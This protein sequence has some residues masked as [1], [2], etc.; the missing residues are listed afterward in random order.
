MKRFGQAAVAA[1]ALMATARVASAQLS[2]IPYAPVEVGTGISVAVDYA[3]PSSDLGGGTAYGLTGGVGFGRF[4]LSASFGAQDPSAFSKS[5]S[6][7]GRIGMR[8]FGGG[9]NPLSV[10]LQVGGSSTQNIGVNSTGGATTA[11]YVAPGAWAKVNLP[12]IKPWGQVYYTTGNNRP[13]WSKDEVRFAVGVNF[14]LLLGLGVHGAYDW[15]NTGGGWGIGAH[16]N[17]RLP[18]VP[19]VPGV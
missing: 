6:V 19:L 4:G 5:T 3:K 1:V 16:F 14:N 13:S 17:F 12:L 10:G 18:G 11:T 8:L 7:G 2:G 15:G 9:L